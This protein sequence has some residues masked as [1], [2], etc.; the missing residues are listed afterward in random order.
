MQHEQEPLSPSARL[1]G[2]TNEAEHIFNHLLGYVIACT[3]LVAFMDVLGNGRITGSIP[4]L[5]WLW[6]GA[7]GLGVEF[8]VFIL[9][10]RLPRLWHKRKVLFGVN[11]LF[12]LALC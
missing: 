1:A 3:A 11:V 6:T 12:I 8:Q 5:F 7:Q 2:F 4:W 10:R 9:M